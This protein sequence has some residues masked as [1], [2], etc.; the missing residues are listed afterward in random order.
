VDVGSTGGV[1]DG[2]RVGSFVGTAGSVVMAAAGAV[3]A[4]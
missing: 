4:L 2:T 3:V 1:G